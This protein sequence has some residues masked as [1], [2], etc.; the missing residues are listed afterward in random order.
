MDT[1]SCPYLLLHPAPQ[2]HR[3]ETARQDLQSDSNCDSNATLN[4]SI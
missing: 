2:A 3:D 1:N 4:L